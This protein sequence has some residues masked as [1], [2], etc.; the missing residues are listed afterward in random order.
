M[1]QPS[2]KLYRPQLLT[3]WSFK[4]TPMGVPLPS[5]DAALEWCFTCLIP[6]AEKWRFMRP[7]ITKPIAHSLGVALDH[8]PDMPYLRYHRKEANETLMPSRSYNDIR[9]N[10]WAWRERTVR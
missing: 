6:G 7:D 8:T 1:M 3:G 10:I 9:L 4:R 5:M 2:Y